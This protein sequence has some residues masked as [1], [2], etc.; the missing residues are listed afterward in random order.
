MLAGKK[1][2]GEGSA[3]KV[4]EEVN[5]EKEFS[6]STRPWKVRTPKYD[7]TLHEVIAERVARKKAPKGSAEEERDA[8]LA[9]ELAD[10]RRKESA[11][12]PLDSVLQQERVRAAAATAVRAPWTPRL[13]RDARRLPAGPSGHAFREGRSTRCTSSS[14]DVHA[15]RA[16]APPLL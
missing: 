9:V 3:R 2:G 6:F 10:K 11:V 5:E 1:V 15:A 7:K 12:E 4:V 8:Y 16:A 13:T 14:A